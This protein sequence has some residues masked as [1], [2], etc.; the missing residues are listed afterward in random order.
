MAR[1]EFLQRLALRESSNNPHAINRF[2]YLGLYQMGEAALV[3][4][5]FIVNDG[6]MNNNYRDY[7]WT[8]QAQQYGVSS[9]TDFLNSEEAQEAAVA[10]YHERVRGYLRVNGAWNYIGQEVDG[11]IVTESGLLGAAH[12]VGA[13]AVN[14]WLSSGG[15]PP[16]DGNGVTAGEYLRLLNGL[17]TEAPGNPATAPEEAERVEPE[18]DDAGADSAASM[19]D[20]DGVSY[21]EN[22]V[23]DMD[24][25]EEAKRLSV[26][27]TAYAF[28]NHREVI[29]PADK[30]EAY[31]FLRLFDTHPDYNWLDIPLS[32]LSARSRRE[33]EEARSEASG[34]SENIIVPIVPLCYTTP[35]LDKEKADVPRTNGYIYVFV[36]GHL[37]REL[38]VVGRGFYQDVNLRFQAGRDERTATGHADN[39][40]LV[41]YR[42]QGQPRTVE[43]CYADVQWS[44]SRINA[45]GGMSEA[46]P[47]LRRRQG[48][49]LVP[50]PSSEQNEQA[51]AYRKARLQE[52]DLGGYAEGFPYQV[53][54]DNRAALES[55]VTAPRLYHLKVHRNSRIPVVY[56]HDPLGVALGEYGIVTNKIEALKEELQ[57]LQSDEDYHAAVTAYHTFLDEDLWEKEPFAKSIGRAALSPLW[58]LYRGRYAQ[59]DRASKMLR[60]AGEHLSQ[61]R[62][63]DIL[64]VEKRQRLREEIRA[65]KVIYIDFL[66]GR[67]KGES[68]RDR[69]PD[70]VALEEALRDYA[71]LEGEAYAQ[72]WF[73]ASDLIAFCSHDPCD[74]DEGYD[75]QSNIDRPEPEDDP[76]LQYLSQLLDEG[77]PIHEMVFPCE[78]Q[79]DIYT[80]DYEPPV[81]E[82]SDGSGR[83]RPGLFAATIAA[84]RKPP[85]GLPKWLED[86]VKLFQKVVGDFMEGFKKHYALTVHE[87]KLNVFY[88]LAKAANT[89]ELVGM[90]VV[91]AG[92]VIEE[93]RIIVKANVESKLLNRRQRRG[94][95]KQSMQPEGARASSGGGGLDV[96]DANTGR[97][98][99][100]S[101]PT[102]I[103]KI[104]G[105]KPVTGEVFS[106][107]FQTYGADGLA[108]ARADVVTVSADAKPY[109]VNAVKPGTMV[110]GS[111]LQHITSETVHIGNKT[112][113]PLVAV[114]ESV[115]AVNAFKAV[116]TE[117]GLKEYAVVG[118]ASLA[119]LVALAEATLALAGKDI[120]SKVFT[121][122]FVQGT[123]YIPKL[124]NLKILGLSSASLAGIGAIV[125]TRQMLAH[126]DRGDNDAAFWYGVQATAM[127][128][129]MLAALGKAGVAGL[130]FLTPYGWVFLTIAVVAGVLAH[131]F[132]DTPF[133]RWTKYGPFPKNERDKLSR[134]FEG[135]SP[136]KSYQALA[137]LLLNPV[138]LVK[139]DQ[140]EGF[141][142]ADGTFVPDVFVDVLVPGGVKDEVSLEAAFS[143]SLFRGHAPNLAGRV[144]G[145]AGLVAGYSGAFRG[146]LSEPQWSP[147]QTSASFYRDEDLT[148]ASGVAVIGK[149]YRFR[150]YRE[151]ALW[152][153]NVRY[154]TETGLL[155][156]MDKDNEEPTELPSNEDGL[157]LGEV[158]GWVYQQLPVVRDKDYSAMR[159][160]YE[161]LR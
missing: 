67:Y 95:I 32:E 151:S 52:I 57:A 24:R 129:L 85:T 6:L 86:T 62:L 100:S 110:G 4:A 38:K 79:V 7:Q 74:L 123:I 28:N 131:V 54:E 122:R 19:A 30:G 154:T 81:P 111:T 73:V 50:M 69:C 159:R 155:L 145:A 31:A 115:N 148:D 51:A 152:R 113:P 75:L 156:P 94:L 98:V 112:L 118:A 41:P 66:E 103:D 93:G 23:V 88:R 36:D 58:A 68:L 157:E 92:E 127:A 105:M 78:A 114:V 27:D 56:L 14:S 143:V 158:P 135:Y 90:K 77:H 34:Q 133:E 141:F 20:G 39:R 117:D 70:F 125:A 142:D 11:V 8:A 61:A 3:D 37:W 119:A 12:L 107:V 150:G 116:S 130:A 63:E 137:D 10:R 146:T 144:T 26:G 29:I 9:Y 1:S 64:R 83:F 120:A 21:L 126:A 132:T 43:I 160:A 109:A 99:L 59:A 16:A 89:P 47:R 45:L 46:D 136:E 22:D 161:L 102:H 25:L 91:R 5:G 96:V 80:A 124:G 18:R 40:I 97:A 84:S 72:L 13:G 42:F 140:S 87:E 147:I 44:W 153:A 82:R 149:R 71:T 60:E 35:D 17:D 138:V 53:P 139:Q 48:E 2:G 55:A 108:R 49:E 106:R 121:K 128:G 65:E 76:G 101:N 104:H 134:E 15:A 33:L